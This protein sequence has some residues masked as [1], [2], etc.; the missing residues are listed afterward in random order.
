MTMDVMIQMK[1]NTA[2]VKGKKIEGCW[3][4][5]W[6]GPGTTRASKG[7]DRSCL[8]SLDGTDGFDR[9]HAH[10]IAHDRGGF[11]AAFFYHLDHS[12]Y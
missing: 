11:L 5:R 10:R 2:I 1:S 3:S 6:F 12:M 4:N 7:E 9:H 8:R